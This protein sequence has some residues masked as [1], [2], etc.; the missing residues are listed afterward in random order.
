MTP[1][2]IKQVLAEHAKWLA[3]D[4]GTRAN[5]SWADLRGA[6]LREAD[7]RGANLSE[8]NLREANL[9]WASLREADLSEA[10]LREAD[11]RGADLRGADLRGAN[12]REASLSW[13][14]LSGAKGLPEDEA[15]LRRVCEA[16]LAP[17]ALDMQTWHTCE[18]THCLAGW[19]ITL[20][21]HAGRV[22]ETAVGPATAGALLIPRA[23]NLFF[24]TTDKATE[25]CREYLA[26]PQA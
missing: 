11:L 19:A 1:D 15:L 26:T 7:L 8:A 24:A 12:L 16:A 13:A 23:S 3:G 10:D 22:L 18:T 17:G 6:D 25:W 20:S 4:G 2:A 14:D 21:G 9:S 5:L